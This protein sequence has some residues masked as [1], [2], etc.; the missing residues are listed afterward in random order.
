MGGLLKFTT[1]AA[2]VMA[3]NASSHAAIKEI[4][5]PPVA[6]E[7]AKL[8][9]SNVNFEKM[10]TALADAIAK[11]DVQALSAL[12][13]PTF[14]WLTNGGLSG[15]FDLGRDAIHN[16][17][18]AMGFREQGK[19]EDLS[20]IDDSVWEN[21]A[22]FNK[23][24]TY[25]SGG[26]NLVCGPMSANIKDDAGFDR[27]IQ[28]I[29]ADD[30]TAWFFVLTDTPAAATPGGTGAPVGRIG[31]KTAVPVLKTHPPV[32]EGQSGPPATHLQVLLP[33]GKPGWIPIALARPLV[34][35]RLCYSETPSGDWKITTYEGVD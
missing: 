18:V 19:N 11:K 14:V 31:G 4:N 21:L 32:P 34:S 7:T 8:F 1:A 30:S 5:Y 15:D 29:A 9:I 10:R 22:D 17:K 23:E 16:F 27:A 24:K 26:D 20:P 25:F 33:S 12:V 3:A 28:R 6:V 35:D 13:G 2:F